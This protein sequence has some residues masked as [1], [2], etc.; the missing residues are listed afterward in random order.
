L[1]EP[2]G[3]AVIEAMICSKPVI[4]TDAGGPA[5]VIQDEV[6]GILVPTSDAEAMARQIVRLARNEDERLRIGERASLFQKPATCR[7][8]V[9]SFFR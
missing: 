9:G 7:V 4:A 1:G 6:N 3:K 8:I 5:G 2:F